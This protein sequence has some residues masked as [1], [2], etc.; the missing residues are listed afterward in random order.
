MGNGGLGS[1]SVG[2]EGVPQPAAALCL[3]SGGLSGAAW[4]LGVL[5]GLAEAG[6]DLGS[7]GLV[8]GTSAG[9]LV[10]AH[11]ALGR[12]P[13]EIVEG[14]NS[15]TLE[16]RLSVTAL[17][18]LLAAQLWPSRRHAL[19]W[20]GRGATGA[21]W[22]REAA[23]NW[24]ERLGVGLV[25]QPW[26]A[27][28]VIVATDASSGRP[29]YFTAATRIPLERAVAASCAI[30]G[31]FPP[32]LIDDRPHFDGGLRSPANLDVAD[33]CTAVLAIAPLTGSLRAYR[34]PGSQA[35]RLATSAKVV[36]I[37][38]D[39]PARRAIGVDVVAAA[40]IKPALAAGRSVGHA[41]AREVSDL[42]G[43]T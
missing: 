38:P 26:P 20:L 16:G 3:G 33:G 5:T 36:L 40:L 13:S 28:L 41:R 35:A 8:V 21:G 27:G 10:G 43:S 18:R 30:P 32:V 2:T 9:A 15:L 39:G 22:S 6:V 42:L 1:G 25:G 24:V 19:L 12:T 17:T 29:A 4:Q 37:A 31:V 14:L 23:E 7:A 34:R 11:L